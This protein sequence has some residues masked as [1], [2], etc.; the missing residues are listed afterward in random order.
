[1]PA[2]RP[3]RFEL[4]SLLKPKS[5]KRWYYA[6]TDVQGTQG[7]SANTKQF[8][9]HDPWR[10]LKRRP[11]GTS[12]CIAGPALGIAFFAGELVVVVVSIRGPHRC[13]ND[14]QVCPRFTSGSLLFRVGAS[15]R[16][17]F[18]DVFFFFWRLHSFLENRHI[19]DFGGLD[20]VAISIGVAK[21]AA[22]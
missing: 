20:L 2:Q 22:T 21:G 1:M 7:S 17:T 19:A 6:K 8:A 14:P 11:R 15:A 18:L 16:A 9:K 5:E 3:R 12:F 13:L 4:P 10:L